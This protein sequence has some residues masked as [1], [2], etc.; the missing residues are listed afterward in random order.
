VKV[1]ETLQETLLLQKTVDT[2]EHYKCWQR[3]R[4]KKFHAHSLA[5]TELSER[6]T[7]ASCTNAVGTLTATKPV[8]I[9]EISQSV[10]STMDAVT[11][12]QI[13]LQV[14]I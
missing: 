1:V 5:G 14:Y 8:K 12:K 7:V 13:Y 2:A 6:I 4:L 9:V 11:N 3:G 10:R